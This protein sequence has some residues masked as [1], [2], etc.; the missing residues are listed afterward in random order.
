MDYQP[1][2]VTSS[3]LSVGGDSVFLM[4]E[5]THSCTHLLIADASYHT[6]EVDGGGGDA[7]CGTGGGELQ[8]QDGGRERERAV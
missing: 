3:H 5:V 7:G 1:T 8:L 4:E 2:L 6:A